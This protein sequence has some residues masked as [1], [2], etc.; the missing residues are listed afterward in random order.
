MRICDCQFSITG[1]PKRPNSMCTSGHTH[2]HMLL[3]LFWSRLHLFMI[4]WCFPHQNSMTNQKSFCGI[5]T[6]SACRPI[7]R[8]TSRICRV[9]AHRHFLWCFTMFPSMAGMNPSYPSQGPP[10][11]GGMPP[12]PGAAPGAQK[13]AGGSNPNYFTDKKKGEVNE[14][15]NVRNWQS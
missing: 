14:L 2:V 5:Q 1:R 8:T 6:P 13:P 7:A 10:P 9:A 4:A 3:F 11:P 12:P 15:K